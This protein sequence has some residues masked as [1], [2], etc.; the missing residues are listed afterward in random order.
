M[1]ALLFYGESMGKRY[2]LQA[3]NSWEVFMSFTVPHLSLRGGLL[4]LTADCY[5]SVR[6]PEFP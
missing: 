5:P 2:P 3:T 4:L 6:H 1:P